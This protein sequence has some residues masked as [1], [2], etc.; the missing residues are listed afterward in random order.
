MHTNITE[1]IAEIACFSIFL[2]FETVMLTTIFLALLLIL[3]SELVL[4]IQ[5]SA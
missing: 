4:Y 1:N 2:S 5:I 3:A